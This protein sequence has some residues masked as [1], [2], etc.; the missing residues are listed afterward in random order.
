M[1]TPVFLILCG[2]PFSGKTTLA[3]KLVEKFGIARI[4]ID[5]VKW[6]HVGRIYDDD[7]TKDQWKIIFADY[8]KRIQDALHEKKSAL[9]DNSTPSKEERNKLKSFANHENVFSYVIYI[10]TP[11]EEVTKRWLENKK[12][13]ERFDI[14]E[15][16]FNWALE[17]ME[18]PTKDENVII[19]DYKTSFEDFAKK[20][21]AIINS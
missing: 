18:I 8:Y 4:D 12:S 19:F 10:N 3:K 16:T 7:V 13:K 15:K 2:Y 1:A 11:K 21:E 5:E 9:S 6:D 20:L 17:E 14:T